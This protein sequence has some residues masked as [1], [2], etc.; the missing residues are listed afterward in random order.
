[1]KTK[2]RDPRLEKLTRE[3]LD[4]E[5]RLVDAE[6]AV[7]DAARYIHRQHGYEAGTC[8]CHLCAAVR[9]L[10]EVRGTAGDGMGGT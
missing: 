8:A 9:K 5:V 3:R 10:N 4:E 2:D 7:L 1:M 6:R